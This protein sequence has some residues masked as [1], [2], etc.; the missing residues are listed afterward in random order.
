MLGLNVLHEDAY[1]L[2]V[3]KPPG[4]LS[5]PGR[6][7]EKADCAVARAAAE[8]GWIREV[9]RLDQATSG[10]L[11]LARTPEAHRRLS[12]AFADR[13]IE[14]TYTALSAAIP[15]DPNLPGVS[16][17][18]HQQSAAGR[19]T[20][21]QRADLDNRP[22]QIVDPINGKESITNW[23]ALGENGKGFRLELKPTTGRTHQLRLALSLCHGP[24]IGES[25]YNPEKNTGE[26]MRLMLHAAVLRFR[27]PIEDRIVELKSDI[28]F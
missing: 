14:K 1:L 5:V 19:I 24:I 27:H 22:V 10:I 2:A 13:G 25:L 18:P 7:P 20:V 21:Y 6:G 28:P 9:H 23:R 3:E 26:S 17:S 15:E 8:Y 11:L 4:L 12:K 16:F